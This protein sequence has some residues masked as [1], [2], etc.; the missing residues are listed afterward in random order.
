MRLQNDSRLCVFTFPEI[1]SNFNISRL[2]RSRNCYL[3]SCVWGFE[4]KNKEH[5]TELS[6]RTDVIT[7]RRLVLKENS[8]GFIDLFSAGL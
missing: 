2:M 3:V 8:H 1:N 7:I 4:K 5:S 6:F